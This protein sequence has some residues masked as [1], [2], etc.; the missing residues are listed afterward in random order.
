MTINFT[1]QTAANLTLTAEEAAAVVFMR[2]KYNADI[3]PELPETTAQF[4]KR[5]LQHLI[6]S[7]VTAQASTTQLTRQELFVKASP[8]DKA[9]I[10]SIL[11]TYRTQI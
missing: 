8:A 7:W 3:A 2:D 1:S 10:D 11:D 4:F 6:T 9:T 5:S